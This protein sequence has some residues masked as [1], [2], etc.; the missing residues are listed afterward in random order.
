[1][2]V[3]LVRHGE[4]DWSRSLRHTGLTDVELTEEGERQARAVGEALRGRKFA[5]VLSS[6]LQRALETAQLA[7]FEPE[8]RAELAEW[9][10]GAYE[11]LTTAQIR[12]RV[13]DWTIWS[14]DPPS[15]ESLEQVTARAERVVE[16]LG[17]V[18]GDALVF[19]HGHFLRL[20]TARWLELDGADGRLFALDPG[21]LSTL[22]YEREQRVIRSWNV[23][24]AG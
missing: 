15:G 6:P 3:V 13:P 1:V 23:P 21:T 10:Y 8:V 5:L 4:T 11:G 12:E 2:E 9:D 7:G 19:S 16:A 20:V 14:H 24:V 17:R 18:E 22:G